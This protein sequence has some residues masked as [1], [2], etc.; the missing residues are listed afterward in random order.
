[1]CGC[2]YSPNPLPIHVLSG[3]SAG[4][5]AKVNFSGETGSP[6]VRGFLGESDQAEVIEAVDGKDQ[7]TYDAVKD[8]SHGE[9]KEPIEGQNRERPGLAQSVGA[10]EKVWG[11]EILQ[12]GEADHTVGLEVDIIKGPNGHDRG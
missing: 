8:E 10:V 1:M 3:V 7:E 2:L 5:P 12:E 4:R 9:H 6:F 11:E